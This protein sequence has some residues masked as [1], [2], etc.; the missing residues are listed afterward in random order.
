MQAIL[1]NLMKQFMYRK[2]NTY[3]S[4]TDEDILQT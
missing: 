1:L 3:L 4:A 2:L